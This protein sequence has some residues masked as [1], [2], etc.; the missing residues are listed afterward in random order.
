MKLKCYQNTAQF[1]S[2]P[3]NSAEEFTPIKEI[4][5]DNSLSKNSTLTQVCSEDTRYQ[6]GTSGYVINYIYQPIDQELIFKNILILGL[7]SLISTCCCAATY[8]RYMLT[9]YGMEGCPLIAALACCPNCLFPRL[10]QEVVDD[11]YSVVRNGQI[12]LVILK[13]CE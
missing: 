13:D 7:V 11:D 2:E 4:C 9:H 8:H 10:N 3:D 5:I 1:T 12:P 6:Q